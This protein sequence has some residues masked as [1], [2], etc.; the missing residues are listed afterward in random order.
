[1]NKLYGLLLCGGRSSRMGQDKAHL[2][3]DG[4]SLLQRGLALLAQAGC[5]Q[6][7]AGGDYPEAAS[8]AD[9]PRWQGRGPLAG[10]ASALML[11]PD[12][13]WL[14]LPVDMP[15]VTATMLQQVLGLAQQLAA[16]GE[17]V[18]MAVA[19]SQ[20]PLLLQGER[21]LPVLERLLESPEGRMASVGALIQAL[22]LPLLAPESLI[23]DPQQQQLLLCNTNTPEEWHHF[24][25]EHGL[26]PTR[27]DCN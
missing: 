2:M 12:A 27:L 6:V 17:P 22:P 13:L 3:L 24:R 25:Q 23:A 20:F 16:D 11:E 1:M 15:G 5:Q 26:L 4:Q 21:A 8:I 9:L 14:I 7:F 18:G 19:D 10:I